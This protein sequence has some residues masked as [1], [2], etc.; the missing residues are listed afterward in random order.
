M[1]TTDIIIQAYHLTE[2]K[3]KTTT[4]EEL[5]DIKKPGEFRADYQAGNLTKLKIKIANQSFELDRLV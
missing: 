5:F 2:H 1:E 4:L 3:I